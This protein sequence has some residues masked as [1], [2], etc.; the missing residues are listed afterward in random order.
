MGN[1]SS[2]IKTVSTAPES[3][4]EEKKTPETV[5]KKNTDAA[6]KLKKASSQPQT[7][8]QKNSEKPKWTLK[9]VWVTSGWDDRLSVTSV[10]PTLTS[11]DGKT[12]ITAGYTNTT[13]RPDPNMNSRSQDGV[14]ISVSTTPGTIAKW[15]KN[16]GNGIKKLF[17]KK[18]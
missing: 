7:E 15:F 6:E 9:P 2:E 14:G 10:W 8:E 11:P 17:K 18:K 5:Q 13:E 1:D 3:T 12:S 16:L 4:K